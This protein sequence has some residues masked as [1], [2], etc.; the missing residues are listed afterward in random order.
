MQV[1]TFANVKNSKFGISFWM[2]IHD[3]TG[4]VAHADVNSDIECG[5]L[6]KCALTPPSG[7]PSGPPSRLP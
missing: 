6:T 5:T 7:P 4:K 1:G 2:T 3:Y